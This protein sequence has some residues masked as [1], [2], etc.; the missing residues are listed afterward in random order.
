MARSQTA[1]VSRLHRSR[2]GLS[3]MLPHGG[4][5]ALVGHAARLAEVRAVHEGTGI[6]RPGSRSLP[7]K[8]AL[9]LLICIPALILSLPLWLIAMLAIYVESR[10]P[11]LFRQVRL[12]ENG[13]PFVCYKFRT[14]RHDPE[15]QQ[16][17]IYLS[18]ANR[19]MLGIPLDEPADGEPESQDGPHAK[20]GVYKLKN[21]PRVTRVGR[22]LRRASLDELP[23]V[24]NVL[25]GEMSVV[26]PR[27]P[28]PHELER[29]S[30]RALARLYVRPG[31]TGLWQVK[32]RGR[33]SFDEMIEMDLD[34]VLDNTLVRDIS[35][36]ARTIPSVLIG[37]GAA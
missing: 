32:G 1:D 14:M 21:D 12:G 27:P 37:R 4:Q 17:P 13:H 10:G 20:H 34:Y 25:R 33:V 26:G 15:Q 9:D 36:I 19:W 11:V 3:R 18:I 7:A 2:G 30:D 29:Y 22:F 16:D 23:Q 35:I 31:M 5:A 6:I 24:I 28:I 8:R